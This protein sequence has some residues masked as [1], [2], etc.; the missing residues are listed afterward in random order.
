MCILEKIDER[1]S[2]I[3]KEASR[4]EKQALEELWKVYDA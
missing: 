3:E 4:L 1:I 2:L